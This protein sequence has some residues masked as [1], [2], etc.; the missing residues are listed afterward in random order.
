MMCFVAVLC[1]AL[2]CESRKL[3]MVYDWDFQ[4]IDKAMLAPVTK[5]LAPVANISVVSQVLYHTPKSSFS[6]WE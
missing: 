3:S 4:R 5:A 6:S 1:T 2:L